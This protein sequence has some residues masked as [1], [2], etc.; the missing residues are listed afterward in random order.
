[1]RQEINFKAQNALPK[2]EASLKMLQ[3]V[4][5]II[6]KD[7]NLTTEILSNDLK[8]EQDEDL[9]NQVGEISITTARTVDMLCANLLEQQATL[10]MADET[11]HNDKPEVTVST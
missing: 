2:V 7:L 5:D 1:M 9:I 6:N 8:D 11:A 10:K 3:D 4:L